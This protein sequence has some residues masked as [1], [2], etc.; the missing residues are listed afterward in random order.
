MATWQDV[1]AKP[2]EDRRA[3]RPGSR[4]YGSAWGKRGAGPHP[5]AELPLLPR[6]VCLACDRVMYSSPCLFCLGLCGAKT[7]SGNGCHWSA[8]ECPVPGHS[9]Y[10]EYTVTALREETERYLDGVRAETSKVR[11]V[12]TTRSPR[13][14]RRAWTDIAGSDGQPLPLTPPEPYL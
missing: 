6:P 1:G 8:G 14:A 7:K 9:A 3:A 4:G 11:S 10:R 2:P 5:R 12:P 13:T